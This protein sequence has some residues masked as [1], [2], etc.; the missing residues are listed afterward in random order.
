MN[1]RMKMIKCN[2]CKEDAVNAFTD[3]LTG[4]KF[5]CGSCYDKT[6]GKWG[7]NHPKTA[8]ASKEKYKKKYGDYGELG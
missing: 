3:K 2:I 6:F 1:G 8:R 7:K 4:Y 5:V